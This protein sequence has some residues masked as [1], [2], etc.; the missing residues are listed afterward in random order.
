MLAVINV[1]ALMSQKPIKDCAGDNVEL[2]TYQG[3]ILPAI[4]VATNVFFTIDM[5]LGMLVLGLHSG[6][7]DALSGCLAA[8]PTLRLVVYA[9]ALTALAF[10]SV[11]PFSKAANCYWSGALGWLLGLLTGQPAFSCHGSGF[12]AS[13]MQVLAD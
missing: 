1:L 5:V 6:A 13:L 3:D 10:G 2:D 7:R 8:T 9:L 4:D 11:R 12:V